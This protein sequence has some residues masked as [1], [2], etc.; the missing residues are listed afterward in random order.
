[1]EV[2]AAAVRGRTAFLP[3][4]IPRRKCRGKSAEAIVVIEQAGSRNRLVSTKRPEDLRI[5]KG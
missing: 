1:M 5:M 4:E 3:G 2:N